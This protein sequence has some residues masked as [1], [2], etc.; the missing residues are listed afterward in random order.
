MEA[1]QPSSI[2]TSLGGGIKDA[3]TTVPGHKLGP[4]ATQNLPQPL[5]TGLT[6][7]PSPKTPPVPREMGPWWQLCSPGVLVIEPER[8][9]SAA[10]AALTLPAAPKLFLFLPHRFCCQCLTRALLA[11][12]F[13]GCC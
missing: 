2:K 10:S 8:C 13:R 7:K 12:Q 1:L 3:E 5:K 9:N 4:E 11:G 6:W